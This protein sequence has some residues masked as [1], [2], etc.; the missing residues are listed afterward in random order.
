ME[1]DI[2]NIF[3]HITKLKETKRTGW[4]VRGIDNGESIADHCF[5]TAFLSMLISDELEFNT[6]KAVRMALLH[7][8]A[9]SI[10]GDIKTP[11]KEKLGHEKVLEMERSALKKVFS[12]LPE[13]VKKG[14][15]ELIK[16][17]LESRTEEA[18]LVNEIDKLEMLLQAKH[19]QKKHGVDLEEFRTAIAK[20]KR[21][22]ILK[23][24]K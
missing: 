10:T 5:S 9:E 14:Y 18:S 23:V 3:E 4:V 8:M 22:D 19:Y 21:S 16:E 1:S 13:K 2:E 12:G 24:L 7:D 15:D 6:E 17:L 20:I 11:E